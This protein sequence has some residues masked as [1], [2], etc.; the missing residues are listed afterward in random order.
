MASGH[1]FALRYFFFFLY[2][3]HCRESLAFC[4]FLCHLWYQFF[5]R[6]SYLIEGHKWF[7]EF[8][9][10]DSCWALR[11]SY[12]PEVHM[13]IRYDAEPDRHNRASVP[14]WLM[15]NS[16]CFRMLQVTT[17]ADLHLSILLMSISLVVWNCQ[18]Q[19]L[20]LVV[21]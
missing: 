11:R 17:P 10:L 3:P 12:R 8:Y 14:F 16:T 7:T 21:L 20:H 4:H 18:V 13:S 9:T 19:I 1:A 6:S 5:L 2:I 15:R